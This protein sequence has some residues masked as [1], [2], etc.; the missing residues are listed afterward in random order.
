MR[1]KQ[2]SNK[3]VKTTTTSFSDD[4]NYL[5]MMILIGIEESGLKVTRIYYYKITFQRFD[6]FL[7]IL[8]RN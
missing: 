5:M 3:Y 4:N 8:V 7:K 1:V 2:S 6:H